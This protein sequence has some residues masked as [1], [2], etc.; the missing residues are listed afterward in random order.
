MI[1]TATASAVS[2]AGANDITVGGF[3][4]ALRF[5]DTVNDPAIGEP[6]LTPAA[7]ANRL[8]KTGAAICD[9]VK[10]PDILGVVEVENLATLTELANYISGSCASAPAYAPYLIE[11]ND[12]GGIDVGFSQHPRG[13][14]RRVAGGGDFDR[15]GRQ[16]HPLR[17]H[18]LGCNP[19]DAGCTSSLLND[20]PSLVLR[21][22]VNFTDGRRYPLTVII[23]HLR[24]LN[25]SDDPAD[26][27]RALSAPSRRCS[28]A[29]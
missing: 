10:A 12:V 15:P 26:G 1:G 23:N 29:T 13:A 11:G 3:K 7:F 27:P 2:T 17:H 21:A 19:A 22:A 6:V 28:S 24:S 14:H 9:W 16:G 18:P 20:R 5:F 8:A 4:P 25:G